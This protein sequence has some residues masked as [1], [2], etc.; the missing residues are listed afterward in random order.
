MTHRD[1]N[2]RCNEPACLRSQ[3]NTALLQAAA[4]RDAVS[5]FMSDLNDSPSGCWSREQLDEAGARRLEALLHDTEAAHRAF[6][7]Y[8]WNYLTTEAIEAIEAIAKDEPCL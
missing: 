4:W 7:R 3:L 6:R 8:L 1:C 2:P 5:L